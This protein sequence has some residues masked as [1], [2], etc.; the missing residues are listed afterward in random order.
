[1]E[2]FHFIT[3]DA[4]QKSPF[5]TIGKDWMLVTAGNEEKANTMTASWGGLGIMWGKP[6]AFI[7]LRP[8]RY[9]KEFV[10]KES[11]LSLSFLNDTYRKTL[12]Y[13]GTVSGRDEADKIEKSGLTLAFEE[14]IP[15]FTE[16]ETVIFGKVL[17]QQEMTPAA[18]LAPELDE[19]WYPKKDYHT[20]Y[21]AEITGIYSK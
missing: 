2:Q 10:D 7:V 5:K 12:N 6:V 11:T 1:M 15:Y 13:L 18:F 17:Y 20:L 8:Q 4:F 3:P 9:T 21:I 19:K 16:S 14:G